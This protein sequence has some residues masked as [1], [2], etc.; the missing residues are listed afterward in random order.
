MNVMMRKL[1]GQ[2]LMNEAAAD[3]GDGGGAAPAAPAGDAAA[4]AAPAAAPAAASEGTAPAQA[5]SLLGGEE[6]PAAEG[7]EEAATAGAPEAYA[8][9][10]L[11]EGE[12]LDE[13]A[14]PMVQALFKKLDLPQDK[15]QEVMDALL[16]IDKARQPT[17]EQQ[18]AFLEERISRLNESWG[19]ECRNL[20]E[21]GG[22]NFDASLKT[23]SSVMVKFGTPELRQYLNKSALGSH[24]E[25]FKFIHAI[26]SAM[27][28]DTLEHGGAAS[29]GPRSAEEV[30]WP[31][32]TKN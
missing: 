26:G 12:V 17:P 31:A 19:N 8:D 2:V 23:A 9:F 20:P 28:Q 22:A 14:A 6:S 30:L 27:S 29:K 18:E 25:F 3:G 4:P 16:E 1:L 21:I 10:T 15:A 5:G 11:P 13:A 32:M 7:G 24:P